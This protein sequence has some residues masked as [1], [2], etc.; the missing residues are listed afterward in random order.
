MDNIPDAGRVAPQKY[1][2]NCD[3]FSSLGES[4][5]QFHRNSK[6]VTRSVKGG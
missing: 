6:K 1:L 3:L 4:Q 5:V 2:I